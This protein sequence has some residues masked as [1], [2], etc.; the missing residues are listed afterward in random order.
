ML[1]IAV[2]V[3][4]SIKVTKSRLDNILSYTYYSTYST[5]RS[6]TSNMLADFNLKD[7]IYQANFN[8]YKTKISYIIKG[9]INQPAVA[10]SDT[11]ICIVQSSRFT[12]EAAAGAC[13]SYDATAYN[14]TSP[15]GCDMSV[16]SGIF[17]FKYTYGGVEYDGACGYN[18]MKQCCNATIMANSEYWLTCDAYGGDYGSCETEP[19]PEPTPDTPV[20]PSVCNTEPEE[21]EVSAKYCLGKEFDSTP[22]VCGWVDITP[23]PP[24][25]ETGKE[26]SAENCKCVAIPAT[27]PKKGAKFCELFERLV[28]ISPTDSVCDGSIVNDDTT[29]FSDLT[30]DLILRNGVRLYN[31]HKDPELIPQLRVVGQDDE[32]S[33]KDMSQQGYIVYADVDGSK[34][35]SILWEDVYPFFI[36]LSG[37]VIP[38][39]DSEANPDGSG[40]D[41]ENHLQVSVK[42]ETFNANGFRVIKWLSKSVSFKDG[43]CQSG[44]INQATE[45]CNGA[46]YNSECELSN[47]NCQLKV[48]QPLKF[49]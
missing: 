5:L 30:P 48:I 28:N 35:S 11:P 34:G 18:R 1:I 43:A 10:S 22:E 16:T 27:L 46:S 7:E 26:W 44:Y 9:L 41:S 2:V 15:L 40:G 19:T 12:Y 29:E 20:T 8:D 14:G 47:S 23:W 39:Y 3:G 49:F 32:T 13:V 33:A 45:Y 4:V 21:S 24:A 37:R 42:N 17:S 6:V 31:V 38:A 36:T 25:C